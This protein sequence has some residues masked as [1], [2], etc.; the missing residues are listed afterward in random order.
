MTKFYEQYH[1]EG[2]FIERFK[3]ALMMIPETNN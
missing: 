2:S 1:W 3:Q